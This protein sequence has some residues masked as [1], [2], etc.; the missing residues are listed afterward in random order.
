MYLL[1]EKEKA[2]VKAPKDR[3]DVK[4][5]EDIVDQ[6]ATLL[7]KEEIVGIIIEEIPI[8]IDVLL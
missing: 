4:H 2:E 5:Q 3:I 8:G 6:E 7:E 1:V